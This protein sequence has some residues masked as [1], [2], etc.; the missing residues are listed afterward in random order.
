MLDTP[1]PVL[2]AHAVRQQKSVISANAKSGYEGIGSAGY[3][4]GVRNPVIVKSI[5]I[6]VGGLERM[7]VYHLVHN[8]AGAALGYVR[9]LIRPVEEDPLGLRSGKKGFICCLWT[10]DEPDTGR[11][12]A[13]SNEAPLAIR[14]VG[15]N[16]VM[17]LPRLPVDDFTSRF[18]QS[19][20]HLLRPL[21]SGAEPG[22]GW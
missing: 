8:S 14:S 10:P 20:G 18:A 5:P 2:G 15:T 19:D 4:I 11:N 1:I 6:L 12:S 21:E 7:I 9:Y 17:D 13:Q 22:V 16:R 3:D